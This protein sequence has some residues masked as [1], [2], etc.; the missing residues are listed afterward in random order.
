M[1]KNDYRKVIH[2]ENTQISQGEITLTGKLV[3]FLDCE[4]KANFMR[5]TSRT[6]RC[7]RIGVAALL[8]DNKGNIIRTHEFTDFHKRKF[9]SVPKKN[10]RKLFEPMIQG[11]LSSAFWRAIDKMEF[12]AIVSWFNQVTG[13]GYVEI[14]KLN[15]KMPIFACNIK[16]KKTWYENTACVYYDKGQ[17][18]WVRFVHP[19]FIEGL[20]QGTIDV[21][22]WLSFDRDKLTFKCDSE[23][24]TI[25]G[26]FGGAK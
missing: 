8:R 7:N 17:T 12:H 16:G 25:N 15:Q 20:T 5:E 11:A 22:K 26:L 21:Q 2:V 13:Q 9:G 24:K 23:G 18:V 4:T 14:P 3:F 1:K 6:Y 10:F 19:H